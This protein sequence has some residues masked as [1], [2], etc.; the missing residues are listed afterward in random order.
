MLTLFLGGRDS[1]E[2]RLGTAEERARDFLPA[3]D[4]LFAG[5]S[6]HYREGSAIRMYWPSA[7]FALG[8]YA[9]YLPGQAAWSGTEGEAV[10]NLYFCG[11]HTSEDFQGYMEGAAESGER[12]AAEVLAAVSGSAVLG[13]RSR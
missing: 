10:G 3:V 5:A 4:Q 12:A 1:V 13:A 7:P 9:C 6:A 8:S 11:E 2:S